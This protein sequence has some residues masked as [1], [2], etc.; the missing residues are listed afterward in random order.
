MI[1]DAD[2]D[3]ATEIGE[4]LLTDPRSLKSL[5]SADA[6]RYGDGF[7]G[8]IVQ[9]AQSCVKQRRAVNIKLLLKA[10]IVE[11]PGVEPQMVADYVAEMVALAR[12]AVDE[13]DEAATPRRP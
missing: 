4:L 8:R 5:R 13:R 12:V 11:N 7:H 2:R 9:L 10:L 1:E 6:S 3:E